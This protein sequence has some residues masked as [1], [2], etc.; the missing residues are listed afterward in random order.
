MSE[1]AEGRIFGYARVSSTEQHLDRQLAELIKYVPE[2]NIV[3]DKQSGKNL[4]RAGYQALKGR[5]GLMT[6][7]KILVAKND[8]YTYNIDEEYCSLEWGI[9]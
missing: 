5:F 8:G 6:M 3:T 1:R 7:N 4:E 9:L 2:E